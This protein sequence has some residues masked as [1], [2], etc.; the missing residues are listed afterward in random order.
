MVTAVGDRL[1]AALEAL[2]LVAQ[3]DPDRARK[4]NGLG[5]SKSDVTAGHRL[6]ATSP[7]RVRRT[8]PA[9]AQA[10]ALAARYRRQVPTRLAF[11]M[12]L[13]DQP[14]LFE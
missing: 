14:D 10:I 11:Q 13:T 9:T 2:R 1:E 6:A 7:D 4:A 3:N 12:H 5:F 8:T